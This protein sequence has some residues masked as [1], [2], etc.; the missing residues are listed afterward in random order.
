MTG[1]KARVNDMAN[2]ETALLVID[3]QSS[4]V[5][6]SQ[7]T[8]AGS[9]A[10]LDRIKDLLSKAR[11]AG[12]PVIYVQH[13]SQEAGS[14]LAPG[15]PGWQIHPSVAPADGEL[16]INKQSADS[17][18]D[19]SLNEELAARGIKRLVITGCRTQYCVDT[20]CRSAIAHGY[21][22]MLAK[23]AH[24]T[25]DSET[26]SAKQIIA[27]HNETLHEL[28]AGDHMIRVLSSSEVAF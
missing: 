21:D 9:D 25:V 5:D 12:N 22:V 18:F 8:S 11:T 23:D 2:K 13:D 3:V 19:T 28:D 26:L 15:L 10:V 1:S 14:P 6:W 7:P 17:F 27:H 24:M 20:T 4:V 16:V